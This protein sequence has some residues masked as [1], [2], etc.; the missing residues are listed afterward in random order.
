L[1]C[2]IALSL[3]ATSTLAQENPTAKGHWTAGGTVRFARFHDNQ[4]D[5]TEL[6]FQINPDIGYFIL[7]G[8]ALH[9]AL[10]L[11]WSKR[12]RSGTLRTWGGGAGISYYVQ[13]VSSRIYPYVALRALRIRSDF[14]PERGQLISPMTDTEWTWIAST[15]I[16]LFV[17]RN[18]AVTAELY[19]SSF[20]VTVLIDGPS[21]MIHN[22]NSSTEVG[23]QFGIRGFIF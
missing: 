2:L 21:E 12:E 8:L 20:A 13:G 14:E 17:S 9:S 1:L 18:I 16:A 6:G 7:D 5:Q 11:G 3:H 4:N 23:L 19:R 15:G 22:R 10:R